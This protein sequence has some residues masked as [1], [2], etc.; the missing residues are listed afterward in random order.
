MSSNQSLFL[1]VRKSFIQIFTGDSIGFLATFLAGYFYALKLG[2]NDYGVWQTAKIFISYSIVFTFSLPFVMRRDF[3][4]L[5]SEGK[6]DEAKK[7]AD[8]VFTYEL[9]VTPT[10]SILLILYGLFFVESYLLKISIIAVGLIYI[11]QFI[12]GY[13]NILAKGLNNYNLI[14]KA[15][16]LNGLLTILTIPFVYWYGFEALLIGT[17]ILSFSNSIYYY[18][19]RP[20]NYKVFWNNKLF[21]TLII[22]SFPLYLQDIST[23][24][25]DSIDRIII[26]K[27]LTFDQVGFYSL[28]SLVVVPLRLLIASFSLVLFT[29]LNEKYG[30][31]KDNHVVEKHVLIPHH[32]LSVF[33]PSFIGFG[34][35]LLPFIVETFLPKYISGITS[36][37]ILLFATFIYLLNT[38]S[39]N[40]LFIVNKQKLTAIIFFFVGVVKTGFCVLSM[41][42]GFGII[43]IAISTLFAFILLDF[44]MLLIVFK[45]LK[46][47]TAEFLKYIFIE[48][49]P[50]IWVGVNC[51]IIIRYLGPILM[52]NYKFGEIVSLFLEMLYLLIISTPNYIIGYKYYNRTF[53]NR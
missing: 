42:Y 11:G 2:P 27:Y 50:V 13:S 37:Q 31:S 29:N 32:V 22:I 46:K 8:L 3:I 26:A 30:F 17:I 39:A 40:A 16:I 41:Y 43:G 1:K 49:A 53:K 24:I 28:A 10:L 5:R 4:M 23:T 19:K 33:L 7:I 25:F 20:F 51:I 12:G 34:I 18:I 9:F 21:K 48:S 38:F 35:I 52:Y 14:K 6:H 44:L 45:H 15:S 47:K 36:A